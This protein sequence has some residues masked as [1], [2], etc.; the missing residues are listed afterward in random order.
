[1]ECDILRAKWGYERAGDELVTTV[2]SWVP[3]SAS[4]LF[5]RRVYNGCSSCDIE[6]MLGYTRGSKG[7]SVVFCGGPEGS[8]ILLSDHTTQDARLLIFKDEK[9]TFF[10]KCLD[11]RAYSQVRLL[12]CFSLESAPT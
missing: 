11:A 8:S 12:L 1:M 6:T 4:S 10:S 7:I 3:G 5:G 9:F 2:S